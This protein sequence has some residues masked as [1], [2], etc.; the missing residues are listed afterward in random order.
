MK[1]TLPKMLADVIQSESGEVTATTHVNG[2]EVTFTLSLRRLV[3]PKG[4]LVFE[5]VSIPLNLDGAEAD[6]G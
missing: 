3:S 6:S 5:T 4:E 1:T 2:Y